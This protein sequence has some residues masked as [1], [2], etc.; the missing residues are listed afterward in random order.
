[1]IYELIWSTLVN[2]GASKK[3]RERPNINLGQPK[4]EEFNISYSSEL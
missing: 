3:V 1:M 4:K 2:H